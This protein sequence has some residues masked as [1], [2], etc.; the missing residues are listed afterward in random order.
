MKHGV[1]AA[2]CLACRVWTLQRTTRACLVTSLTCHSLDVLTLT[3]F[4]PPRWVCP[5]PHLSDHHWCL[6]VPHFP[7]SFSLNDFYFIV[8]LSCFTSSIRRWTRTWQPRIT[9]TCGR[10]GLFPSGAATRCVCG[11]P[12]WA[13]TSTP[14]SSSPKVWTGRSCS[15]W[16]VKNW[17]WEKTGQVFFLFYFTFHVVLSIFKSSF[18]KALSLKVKVLVLMWH[19]F[20]VFIPSIPLLS[21][22]P[23]TSDFCLL[24]AEIN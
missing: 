7:L 8:W 24:I 15:S 18:I 5:P 23:E 10:I 19:C 16:M 17:R 3:L 1:L 4:P 22:S 13:W 14:R 9:T 6:L 12:P 20:S 21:C 11:W 2:L